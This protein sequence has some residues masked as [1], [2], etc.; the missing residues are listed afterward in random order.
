[1]APDTTESPRFSIPRRPPGWTP[2]G[3]DAAPADALNVRTHADEEFSYLLG[4]WR[5][6]QLVNGHRWSVDDLVAAHYAQTFASVPDR[7]LD[8]GCGIGSVLLMHAWRFENAVGFGIEAQSRSADL[9]SRSATYNG[10]SGRVGVLNADFR[11][12]TA[13]DLP[14]EPSVV[15][16]TPPYF[17]PGTHSLSSRPQC[18]P[19]RGEFRGSSAD[20]VAAA[21]R[22]MGP[23]SEFFV[24]DSARYPQRVPDAASAAGL[25]LTRVLEV[26]PRAGKACLFHVFKLS[27][28]AQPLRRDRLVVRGADNDYA[29]GFK[30][31]RAQMG[32]PV[33][34]A[35]G[36]KVYHSERV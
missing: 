4:N 10:C 16:G 35:T 7:H 5:I 6:L 18:G 24:C 8:L 33:K 9:A 36:S 2:P 3:P 34:D 22:L 32:M 11:F 23:D 21:A 29:P 14:F 1:M 12:V 30:S 25:A 19:C 27:R 26:I 15:T 31:L 13:N 28:K 17:P 20:Y